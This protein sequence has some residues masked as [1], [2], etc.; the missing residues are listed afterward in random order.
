MMVCGPT[1]PYLSTWVIIIHFVQEVDDGEHNDEDGYDVCKE[2]LRHV[3][4]VEEVDQLLAAWRAIVLTRLLFQRLFQDLLCELRVVVEVEGDV[5]DQEVLVH[6]PELLVDD[7][8]LPGPCCSNQHH[9]EL[10]IDEDVQ[11][12][13]DPDRLRVVDQTSLR[14]CGAG[15]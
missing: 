7:Q 8:R 5:G 4:V 12:V 1:V 2:H 11:E 6:L 9:R 15:G 3:H 14:S 13:L 10:E